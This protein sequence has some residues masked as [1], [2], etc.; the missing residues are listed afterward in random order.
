MLL[1]ISAILAIAF[2]LMMAGCGGTACDDLLVVCQACPDLDD[3][4]A[5]E[6]ARESAL[7]LPLGANEACLASINSNDWNSC[8]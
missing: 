4:V 6:A 3:R 2:G 7:L 1:R 5:C 8:Q